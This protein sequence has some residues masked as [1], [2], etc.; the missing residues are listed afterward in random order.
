MLSISDTAALTARGGMDLTV[1]AT[2]RP[3]NDCNRRGA[4][5]LPAVYSAAAVHEG[6]ACGARSRPASSDLQHL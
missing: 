5:L 4:D 6:G 2:P 3:R 1:G